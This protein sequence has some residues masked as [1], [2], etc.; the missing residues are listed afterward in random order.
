MVKLATTAVPKSQQ[1]EAI[2]WAALEKVAQKQKESDSLPEGSKHSV[3]LNLNGTI[4]GEPFDQSFNSVLSIGH[5]Q[6][7]SLIHI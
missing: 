1:L 3:N 2:A 5:R 6:T 7:L 4:D